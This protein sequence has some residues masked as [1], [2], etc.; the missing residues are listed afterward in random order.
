MR[1]S[2]SGTEL[3]DSLFIKRIYKYLSNSLFVV[4]VVVVFFRGLFITLN[5]NYPCV[6]INK[7]VLRSL[8]DP[9]KLAVNGTNPTFFS[10]PYEFGLQRFHYIYIFTPFQISYA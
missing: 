3:I 4:V 8:G 5:L 2:H 1:P 9:K 7:T 6:I 10:F